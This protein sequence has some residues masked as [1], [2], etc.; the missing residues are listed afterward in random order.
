MRLISYLVLI[1][2]STNYSYTQNTG[3]VF[4]NDSLPIPNVEIYFADQDLLLS[5]D[6]D[7]SFIIEKNIPDK[8]YI[9]ISKFGFASK[10]ILY[11][12][13]K[14]LLIYLEKL[15]VTLDEV[16]VSETYSELGNSKFTNIEK[17]KISDVFLENNT[18]LE[19]MSHLSG[20][21]L[22]SSG[23][24]IQKL[25]IRGLSGM[26]VVTYLNGMQINNQQWANDHGV[27]F[28]DL[29][30]SEVELIK[31]SSA[32][33][34]GSESIGGL[35][36]FKD[37]PFIKSDKIQGY[38]STKFNN[39]NYSNSN[40]FGLK[41]NKNKLFVNLYGE[42]SIASDYRLPNGKYFFNSRYNQN[43]IKFSI[44]HKNSKY[45]NIFRYHLHN[46]NLGIPGHVCIGDPSAMEL[47][48]L[49]SSSYD[50][51]DDYKFKIPYQ[52]VTNHLFTYESN[53][54]LNNSKF[55]LYLGHFINNLKEYE[56][57]TR[58][59]FDLTLS[60]T[61]ITPNIKLSLNDNVYQN[62]RTDMEIGSQISLINNVNNIND[63]LVPDASSINI[64]PYFIFNYEINNFGFNSGIRYDYKHLK[65]NDNTITTDGR[66]F[67]INYENSFSA[68]SIS[69][70][71]YYNINDNIFRFSFSQA[72]RSPHFS[73]LFSNGVHHG[74]NRYEIGD[75]GLSIEK[76]NQFD[77]KYQWSNEHFGFVVN[78]FVQNI[79]DFIS[80]TLTDSTHREYD[81]L[82]NQLNAFRVYNYIQYDL[83]QINGIEANIHYHPHYL[84]NLHIEQSYTFLKTQ[85]KDDEFGLSL[86]P[87]NSIKTN[88]LF[89]LSSYDL[90][91]RFKL[92]S[93]SL[94]HLYKFEQN[95][96]SQFEE[97]T[98]SYNVINFK[99]GGYLFKNKLE[100]NFLL[101]NLLNKEY[102]PHTSRVRNV[103][104][105]IPN[106]GRS[107][108]VNLRYVL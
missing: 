107:F 47:S 98:N 7:G 56:L 68:P 76:S 85:N 4:D 49:L 78:P 33:K 95:S 71:I 28:T 32:L 80:I 34:Y 48:E 10:R 55:S 9:Y 24:G 12:I 99:I 50:I 97:K 23:N 15:H 8:S 2:I 29:G 89:N 21:D 88:F 90:L 30:L 70:G 66:S 44:S 18:L 102:F 31:G 105:G 96:I 17:A 26:R 72:Y 77:L 74:T 93:I 87:A 106:P 86:T 35:L 73:E 37:Q 52:D 1:L 69:S 43:A 67:D 103:A 53:L 11:D 57:W 36:F 61:L 19:G 42:Y 82:G 6:K 45:Q 65:S 81:N 38:I 41:W 62:D 75:D 104:G 58:P 63:R 14:P 59:D 27:G 16:G 46:E 91:K 64:G 25:I 79:E 101:D 51:S 94:Y 22:I 60:S 92:S 100:Y 13:K 40:Q 108:S 54:F 39:S 84:H 20:V 5:T 83:V 3:I